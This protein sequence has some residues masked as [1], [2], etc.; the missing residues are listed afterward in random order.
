MERR[1]GLLRLLHSDVFDAHMALSYLWQ[2]SRAGDVGLQDALCARLREMASGDVSRVLP[3]LLHIAVAGGA[4]PDAPP[5]DALLRLLA[6]HCARDRHD[7]AAALFAAEHYLADHRPASGMAKSAQDA[8]AVLYL[9]AVRLLCTLQRAIFGAHVVREGV[10]SLVFPSPQAAIVAA[11]ASLGGLLVPER[12]DGWRSLV[13]VDATASS[14]SGA[15]FMAAAAKREHA[16]PALMALAHGPLPGLRASAVALYHTP[17]MVFAASLIDVSQRVAVL[18]RGKRLRALRTELSLLNHSLPSSVCLPLVCGGSGLSDTGRRSCSSNGHGDTDSATLDLSGSHATLASDL[19]RLAINGESDMDSLSN[20]WTDALANTGLNGNAH[21]TTAR[22]SPSDKIDK[23]QAQPNTTTH[24]RVL[25]LVADEAVVLNSAERAPY[26]VLVEVVHGDAEL[27]ALSAPAE[28]SPSAAS[29]S[30]AA[31][32]SEAWEPPGAEDIPSSDYA[33]RMRAAASM[34]AQISR[35]S[36]QTGV[37]AARQGELAGLKARIIADM[38]ELER[39]RILDA[40]DAG[41]AGLDDPPVVDV[42]AAAAEDSDPAAAVFREDWAAVRARVMAQSPYGRVP[43][44]DVASVIVKAGA[45]MRQEHLACQLVSAMA[46]AWRESGLPLW[47]CPVS[48]LAAGPGGGLVQTV[49]GAVSLHALKKA[50]LRRAIGTRLSPQDALSI[51]SHFLTAFGAPDSDGYASAIDAFVCSLAGYSL[52]TYL[53]AVKDRHDGNILLDAA[54]HLVHID[55]GFMLGTAPGV[56][57]ETAPF[58][59]ASDWLELLGGLQGAHFARFKELFFS[60]FVALRRH[61]ERLVSLVEA[62]QRH[63]RLPCLA[64]GSA[65]SQLRARLLLGQTDAALRAS[66]ERLV[67]ASAYSVFTRLYDSFQYYSHGIL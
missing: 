42:R 28:G 62:V 44:W 49:A 7:A 22:T 9:R 43:G 40:L 23:T 24:H 1:A 2:Y 45:D 16:V 25:R 12:L 53:L 39:S 3:Q 32:E 31:D 56:G 33:S 54:G 48:V 51:R 59:L 46:D 11:G 5:Y 10:A 47:V 41:G 52:A 27:P 8:A 35:Q 15:P 37:S 13:G 34:L 57:I 67:L 36:G 38:R 61:A 30:S 63:S 58:K 6:H 29:T 14:D 18:P 64:G 26:M 19:D 66:S 65:A 55:F 20:P 50:A 17:E 4:A 60:G 21:C